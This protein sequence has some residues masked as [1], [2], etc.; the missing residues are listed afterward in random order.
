MGAGC[1]PQ[2]PQSPDAPQKPPSAQVPVAPKPA[3]VAE[4]PKPSPVTEPVWKT[5]TDN[6]LGYQLDYPV[7]DAAK[8]W[9]PS[10]GALDLSAFPKLE[11]LKRELTVK[12]AHVPAGIACPEQDQIKNPLGTVFCH[13][14]QTEGAA[15]SSYRTDTYRTIVN[16][17]IITLTSVIKY[18]NDPRIVAGCETMTNTD[19][20]WEST[21][22]PFD[23]K[24]DL[25]ILD[26]VLKSLGS[27]PVSDTVSMTTGEIKKKKQGVYEVMVS[28]PQID[29]GDA[30]LATAF[31]AAVRNPLEKEVNTLVADALQAEKDAA[32]G[33]G[34]WT[35]DMDALATYQSPRLLNSFVS[36]SIYTG[37]AHPNTIY[38]NVILDRVTKKSLRVSDLFVDAKKGLTFLS[39]A[40][41]KQ[42]TKSEAMEMSDTDWLNTGTEA[43]DANFAQTRLTE[44]GLVITFPPYQ[45]AAYAA[46]PQEVQIPWKDV[47]GLIKTEYLPAAK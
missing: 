8:T 17:S 45:V 31:N 6:T 12:A 35:L 18:L 19:P 5:F 9:S 24:K 28:F 20:T 42:L 27:A 41:R 43:K 33:S 30:A 10:S 25:A 22:R 47:Q 34:S 16:G 46:G 13:D 37:G 26:G 32:I 14:V 21:C 39:T 15:G 3:E 23:E 44:Q 4:T 7:L 40:S 11:H 38:Q 36:G 1:A 29:K 2:A